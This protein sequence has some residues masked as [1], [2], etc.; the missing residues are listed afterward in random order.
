MQ[1]QRHH[2]STNRT[3]SCRVTSERAYRSKSIR[4]RSERE[5]YFVFY[6][7]LLS[8]EGDFIMYKVRQC[9][10]QFYRRCYIHKCEE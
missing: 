9:M 5:V 8:E 4:P 7:L 3:Q 10:I 1:L 2:L 6:E